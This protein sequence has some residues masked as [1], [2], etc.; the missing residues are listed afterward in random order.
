MMTCFEFG[1]ELIK[2]NDIDPV[3]VL[4]W[5]ANFDRYRMKR[6]LLAYWGF[7]HMGTASWIS[8]GHGM[9][10]WDRFM[11]AAKSKEYPRCP[12]RRHF[13]G[14]NAV[15]STEYLE[16]V[17][18]DALYKPILLSRE[19]TAGEVMKKVQEWVGFGPWIAFKVADMLERLGLARIAF[20]VESVFLFD[21]PKEGAQRL[22]ES[23]GKPLE[24]TFGLNKWAVKTILS[25]LGELKAPP[26]FERTINAQEAETIL[27]KHFSYLK[28]RYK[29]GEDIHNCRKSLLRFART[30]TCQ[31][32]LKAGK[33]G[34]LWYT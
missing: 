21:S 19:Q 17:G 22:W 20:D 7:Y 13:R 25:E 29:I 15:K 2:R 23:L 11:R 3:Y 26:R 5:N 31:Q 34:G 24:A 14:L 30:K 9:N 1:R 6:W 4:L 33:V 12:E 28:G 18:L 27:C 32:L 10:Y 16:S 8:E